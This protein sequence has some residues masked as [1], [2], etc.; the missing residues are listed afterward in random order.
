VAGKQ[1]LGKTTI[2][3]TLFD[4]NVEPKLESEDKPNQFQIYAPT[5]D[6]QVFSF[7]KNI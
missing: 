3:K 4:N 1:G 7:G 6:I 2:L 5:E